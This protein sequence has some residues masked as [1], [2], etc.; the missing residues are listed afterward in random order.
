[1]S[2]AAIAALM[3]LTGWVGVEPRERV[4]V[5]GFGASDWVSVGTDCSRFCA[6]DFDGDGFADVVTIN[7][8]RDLCI[9]QSVCGWKAAPWEVLASDIEPGA[10]GLAMGDFDRATPGTEVVVIDVGGVVLLSEERDGR[11]QSRRRIDS[12]VP[13]ATFAVVRVVTDRRG[14]E[15]VRA[16]SAG[17]T[18]ALV[19]GAFVEDGD[20]SFFDSRSGLSGARSDDSDDPRAPLVAFAAPPYDR[21]AKLV[22]RIAGDFNGDG[23]DD[24]AFVYDCREPNRYRAVRVVIAANPGATDQDGDGL[25]DADEAIIGTDP[26]GRDTDG[27]GLLDG[28]EVHG[29]PRGIELGGLISTYDHAVAIGADAEA[30]D[31]QLDPLRQDIIVN[32]SYFEGVDP[33]KFRG[34]M[35]RAQSAYR[36]LNSTNPDGST[37]VALHFRE[38]AG[39]VGADDQRMPWWDVGNKF[40]PESERG[41]MHWLQVTPHGGGQSSETGDMGGSGNGWAVFAHELGHQMSLSHTGD[42]APGWCPLYTSMMNYAY[43]YSFDG[44]GSKPH[45]SSGEFREVMLDER[46]LVERLP[47]P[48]ERLGFLSNHPFRFPIRDNG[49]GTT[50]VDW[51]QNGVFDEGEVEADINYGG[52]THAGERRTHTLVG[53]SPSLAY[54]GGVCMLAA[55]DHKQTRVTIKALRSGEEWTDVVAVAGSATRSDPVLVGGGERGAIFVRRFDGWA[56]ASVTRSETDGSRP[57]VGA[58]QPI[59]GLPDCDLSALAVGDRILLVSRHD[60]DALEWRWLTMGEKPAVGEPTSLEAR[61]MVPVGLAVHPSDGSVT[62][63]AGARHESNGPFCLQV[64]GLRFTGVGTDGEVGLEIPAEW[65]HNGRRVHCTSRPVP[66]YRSGNGPVQ[67]VVFHTGWPDANGLWS[68]WRT[69]RIGNAALDGG[70]LTSQIYDEWTRARVAIGFADGAQ[71]AVYAFRWDS[72]DHRDWATNTMFVAHNGYGIDEKPM[73]DFN[74][75]AKI[76]LWGIRQSILN[77]RPLARE[78]RPEGR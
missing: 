58:L 11:L 72:G 77:M 66:V 78:P 46:H 27:D 71:G 28:W 38:I 33:A 43:S 61:S 62:I 5:P 63:V 7:G 60:T 30:R 19:D 73:R 54:I 64:S 18:W 76:S 41:L 4:D 70:W 51:N 57:N 17:R 26:L 53:S 36:G 12:P 29:L 20:A 69:T 23:V 24:D 16:T 52:S 15:T 48:I 50:L 10:S 56:V 31:R 2:S 68:G 22:A 9:A 49:D 25:T 65:T 35:A 55:S 1:M 40:F 14:I 74:D 75:G 39:F 34:E 3:L 8:N 6:G 32:V 67:L 13:D 21:D 47:F 44:D 45:F 37:G 42:S 59:K